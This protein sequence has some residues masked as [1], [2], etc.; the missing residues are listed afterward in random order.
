MWS[1][2]STSLGHAS[3]SKSK[4]SARVRRAMTFGDASLD[5]QADAPVVVVG[6]EDVV[7]RLEEDDER[8]G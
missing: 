1:A 8:K 6:E 7:G 2:L 5:G 4:S 3:S